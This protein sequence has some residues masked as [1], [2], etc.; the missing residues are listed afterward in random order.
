MTTKSGR[1]VNLQAVSLIDPATGWINIHTIPSA[2][3]DFLANK[4]EI[5]FTT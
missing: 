2:L 5:L 3:A 4:A 1:S